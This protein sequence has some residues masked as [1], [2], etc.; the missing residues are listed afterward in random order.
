M[1]QRFAEMVGAKMSVGT[2][3]EPRFSRGAKV[4]ALTS[5]GTFLVSLDS[6]IV[7]IAFR[8]IVGDFGESNR[9]LLT[10]IFSGYNIAY[11]AALLTAGRFADVFGR[12]KSFIR[13][14]ALFS[15]GSILC[16]LAPTAALLV[17]AR[18]IQA[19]G[20]AILTPASLALVLPEFPVEKRAA[21]I[22]IWG[23]VG[24]LAAATGPI[25]GGALVDSFG[26]R[27]LF[28]INL[29]FCA[30]AI[31]VGRRM[32]TESADTTSRHQLDAYGASLAIPG[33]ALIVY[34][35]V[36]SDEWGWF[37][38]GVIGTFA[39]ALALLV[40]F[41]RHCYTASNP[42]LDLQLF[43]LPFVVA[44]NIA[45]VFFSLGFF[46]M[47]FANTQ[48]LQ[49]VW[50]YS[51]SGSG[52]AFA[53]GP[54]TAAIFAAP[55]GKWA[56]KYGHAKIAAI[57]ALLLGGG[58]LVLNLTVTQTPHYWTHYFP[59]MVATGA[60][61]G[62]SISTLSS[63]AS[64]YLPPTRFAMGSALST[65]SR[66]IGAA[67]GLALVTS[68]LAP[69]LRSIGGARSAAISTGTAFDIRTV[70]ISGFHHAWWLVTAAMF[71]NGTSMLLLFKR[72]TAQQMALSDQ[73]TVS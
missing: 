18:V 39:L 7:T 2:T 46:A 29:P 55:A 53:P 48:W 9:H 21:A 30:L 71:V 62:F 43:K 26:W 25:I 41:V 67:I 12:K 51:T 40:V 32:L 10:W 65:T 52:I 68:L 57:G 17:L 19:I 58:I 56:Q 66:Q 44:A 64:A 4:L 28:F 1:A 11:A 33:V 61:V 14:L 36:Q 23:A 50:G 38:S 35:I 8:D 5:I 72:P 69:T 70:D 13:G 37:S 27:S 22:G 34:A 59:M 24:G 6:S 45:G 31:F 42:L 49:N 3:S 54:L 20:G 15:I 47:F 16:G 73:T 60:G 63:A